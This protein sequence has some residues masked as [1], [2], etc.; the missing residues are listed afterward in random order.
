VIIAGDG[1]LRVPIIAERQR[2]LISWPKIVDCGHCWVGDVI[3]KEIIL[4]NKG[5]EATFNLV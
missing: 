5:G 2:S 1:T 4:N 3:K